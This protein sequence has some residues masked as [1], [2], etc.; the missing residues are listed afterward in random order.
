MANRR[1]FATA[2]LL[3]VC[4]G[5]ASCASTNLA[6]IGADGKSFSAEE[7]ER[8]IWQS[9]EQLEQRIDIQPSSCAAYKTRPLSLAYC[10]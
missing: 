4:I 10:K 7:D 6:P 2:T 9:A 8:K 5:I 3:A 1:I